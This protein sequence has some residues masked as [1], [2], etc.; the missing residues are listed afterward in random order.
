MF[1]LMDLSSQN[2]QNTPT[3]ILSDLLI[4]SIFSLLVSEI[5]TRKLF[6]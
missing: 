6:Q 1:S 3:N 2:P 5:E 4:K